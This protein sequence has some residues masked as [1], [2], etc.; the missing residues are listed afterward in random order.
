MQTAHEAESQ[1]LLERIRLME[2]D[3]FTFR[4]ELS[5]FRNQHEAMVDELKS[6]KIRLQKSL[7]SVQTKLTD[8]AEHLEK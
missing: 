8:S 1:N 3:S 2:S 4:A 7:D 6:E 5:N